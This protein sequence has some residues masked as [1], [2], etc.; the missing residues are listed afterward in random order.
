M[1]SIPFF[2][3]LVVITISASLK[4]TV[5]PR[6]TVGMPETQ[7]PLNQIDEWIKDEEINCICL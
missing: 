7:R 4:L 5:F 6:S 3:V 1:S 2:V